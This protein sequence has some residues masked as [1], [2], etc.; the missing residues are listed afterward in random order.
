[1]QK[2]QKPNHLGNHL[3]KLRES[4]DKVMNLP[5]ALTYRRVAITAVSI[6]ILMIGHIETN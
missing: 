2:S 1:M 5:G 3:G 4:K 6:A